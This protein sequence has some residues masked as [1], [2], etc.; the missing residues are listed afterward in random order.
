MPILSAEQREIFRYVA[1]HDPA[2]PQGLKRMVLAALDDLDAA[3]DRW[4]ELGAAVELEVRLENEYR[5]AAGRSVGGG[6]G[7]LLAV[8]RSIETRDGNQKENLK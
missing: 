3:D 4:A 8:M 7:R 5:T 1:E 2:F 6:A